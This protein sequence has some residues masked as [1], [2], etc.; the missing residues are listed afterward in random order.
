MKRPL[1]SVF[2]RLALMTVSLVVLAVATLITLVDRDRGD[3]DT[4]NMARAIT[5]STLLYQHMPSVAL[6]MQSPLHISYIPIGAL[7][8]AG[9]PSN[10]EP[11]NGPMESHLT[12]MLPRGSTVTLG[13]DGGIW[14][15]VPGMPDA[16]VLRDGMLPL[17]RVIVA[18]VLILIFAVTFAVF[19]AWQM[20]RPIR[21][22][23]RAAQAYRSGRSILLVTPRG[24]RE[25]RELI[26]DFNDMVSEL[27]QA[28]RE[29]AEMLA[30]IAHDLRTP[31]TRMLVRADL[32][33]N[34]RDRAGFVRDTESMSRIITQFLSFAGERTTPSPR[35][36]VDEYCRQHYTDNF[37]K[38]DE[39]DAFVKLS[40]R[41]GPG[42]QLPTVDLDRIL[43]N[44]MENAITYGAP[45]IEV[46]TRV[47]ADHY[48]LTIRDHG[49]GV[50]PE[51][52]ENVLRPFVRLDEARGGHSHC[53]LGLS[54][55]RKLVRH[56]AGTLEVTNAPDGGFVI[57]MTFPAVSP[58]L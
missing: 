17:P 9:C 1:D 11:T 31:V 24:P 5:A 18:A 29:R 32:L 45:P 52:I 30:S 58:V 51:D 57:T 25:M 27:V 15:Q 13:T 43:S 53:G 41:A 22:L 34:D 38:G 50:P 20:N 21:E 16:I 55:V 46:F 36:S 10:C 35:V 4:R 6:E 37:S 3:L 26:G 14:V 12:P 7:L 28:D 42:F 19:L 47:E 40:L 33:S 44:L 56:H 39:I 2:G 8:D 23:A 49:R 54:I 48:L